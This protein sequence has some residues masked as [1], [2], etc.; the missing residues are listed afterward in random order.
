MVQNESEVGSPEYAA[1]TLLPRLSISCNHCGLR[2]GGE[3]YH[4]LECPDSGFDLCLPCATAGIYCQNDTHGWIKCDLEWGE[5]YNMGNQISPSRAI[6]HLTTKM[7]PSIFVPPNASSPPSE[8]FSNEHRFIRHSNTREILIYTCGSPMQIGL[9][10]DEKNCSFIYRSS[11]YD[12]NG[13]ITHTGTVSF[14]TEVEG[15]TGQIVPIT[16]FRTELRAVV[17]ALQFLDWSSD[18]NRSWRSLVI[19]TDSEYVTANVSD[20]LE[21]WEDEEWSVLE[22]ST[23]KRY[24]VRNDDLWKLLLERVRYLHGAGVNVSFWPIPKRWNERANYF[25]KPVPG[26]TGGLTFQTVFPTGPLAIDTVPYVN[27]PDIM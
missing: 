1:A 11:A 13:K 8:L 6:A 18:C 9:S 23:Q 4:C 17:A 10:D 22:T 14:P 12:E 16:S 26:R 5:R 20:R 19:A 3:H 7:Y 2:I 24:E 27:T 25:S 15:P 21:R